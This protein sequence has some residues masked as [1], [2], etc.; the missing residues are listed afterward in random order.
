VDLS[1]DPLRFKFEV[2]DLANILSVK[3]SPELH[4][5]TGHLYCK[6]FYHNFEQM[7]HDEIETGNHVPHTVNEI[8]EAIEQNPNVAHIKWSNKSTFGRFM[9][10][11]YRALN[12]NGNSIEKSHLYTTNSDLSTNQYHRSYEAQFIDINIMDDGLREIFIVHPRVCTDVMTII[13]MGDHLED[14]NTVSPSEYFNRSSEMLVSGPY[15]FD[16]CI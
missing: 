1:I 16:S 3:I 12:D 13:K 4:F 11:K 10:V 8:K 9:I 5:M 14:K 7:I 2:G 15:L 6:E